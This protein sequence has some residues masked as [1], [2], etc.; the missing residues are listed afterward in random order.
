MTLLELRRA[1]TEAAQKLVAARD[2]YHERKKAGKTDAELWPETDKTEWAELNK[3][4]NELVAQIAALE[5]EQ[6]FVEQAAAAEEWLQRSTTEPNRRP[7]PDEELPGAPGQTY[8]DLGATRDQARAIEQRQ[9]DQSLAWRAWSGYD[10]PDTIYD[11]RANNAVAEACQRLKFNPGV[12]TVNLRFADTDSYRGIQQALAQT[13]PSL[14][15]REMDRI[16]GDFQKRNL[17]AGVGQSGGFI[18]VPASV[19][20]SIEL[21]MISYS[22]VLQLADTITTATGEEMGW[23][24]ADD[25]ANEARY[26][27]ENQAV[28]T[29]SVNPDFEQVVWRSYDFES[30]FIRVPFTLFRDTFA[31]LEM[32]IGQMIG[33]RFGRKLETEATTGVA[34]IRGFITRAP[35]GQTSAGATAITYDDVVGLEHSVDPALRGNM[36]FMFHDAILEHLRLLKDGESRP[37]WQSNLIQGVPDSFNGKRYAINQKMAS[38]VATTNKTMAAGDFRYVKVRRVGPSLRIKR[39]V[40]RFAEFDQT[41]FIGLMS[42]DSNLLRPNADAA[43]PIQVLQQ[44]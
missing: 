12:G 32:L 10:V 29:A 17:A 14:R 8:G 5:A 44:A 15:A 13:H 3:R 39:L 26:V 22:G 20:A 1:A 37:L 41:A 27:G 23:P 31:N 25:T 18:T 40:E 35:V 30:G 2:R 4:Y 11:P 34:K 19:V 33:E 36:T 38:S 6:Q 21:A 16:L 7:T 43:S 24:V 9:R 28:S 42:C